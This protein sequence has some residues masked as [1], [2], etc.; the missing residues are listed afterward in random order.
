MVS[1]NDGVLRLN[2]TSVVGGHGF[3]ATVDL[4]TVGRGDALFIQA[5]AS[6]AACTVSSS[7]NAFFE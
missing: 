2:W 1:R 6:S 4:V 5:I 7:L 3:I